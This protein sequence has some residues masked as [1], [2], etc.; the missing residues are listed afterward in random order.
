[1]T[2]GHDLLSQRQLIGGVWATHFYGYDGHG[3]VRFLTD[4][5]GAVTDTYTYDAFGTLIS[6]TGATPNDYLYGGEQ[7]DANAGFYYLRARYM[8]PATGRFQTMDRYEGSA[9]E[10]ASL[11]KY[12]YANSDPVNNIDPTGHFT[13]SSAM[14]SFAVHSVL[15]SLAIS[16][17]LRAL[18]AALKVQAGMNLGAAIQE[19][20]I[21]VAFDAALGLVLGGVLSQAPRLVQIRSVAQS[22]QAFR[23]ARAANSVW[24]L[25]PFARGR[26]IEQMILGRPANIPV[27]NFPVIDDFANGVATSIKSLDLTAA[28]YQNAAGITSRL[29][30][31]AGKLSQFSGRTW[32]GFTVQGSQIQQRVLLVAMEQGAPTVAQAQALRTFIQTAQQQWPNIRVVFQFIP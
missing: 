9:F 27:S 6:Q 24:R 25:N 1:Y 5:A 8:N 26:A 14:V 11:H 10:P 20:A 28:S 16:I 3:S 17:P 29:A 4:T 22:I 15:I 21:G 12:L 19:A 31:Y 7:F 13:I 18:E 2:Y 32:G 30:D 23:A